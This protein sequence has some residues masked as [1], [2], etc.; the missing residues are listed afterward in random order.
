MFTVKSVQK[1]VNFDAFKTNS[2]DIGTATSIYF[3]TRHVY[4]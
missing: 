4:V 1:Q 3:D 2:P